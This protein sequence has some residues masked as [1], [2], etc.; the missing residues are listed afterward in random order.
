MGSITSGK[1]NA[2]KQLNIQYFKG[3]PLKIGEGLEDFE[4]IKGRFGYWSRLSEFIWRKA[5]LS[6]D[7]RQK[8]IINKSQQV[9]MFHQQ[10]FK[11]EETN[12]LRGLLEGL[13][14]INL[15]ELRSEDFKIEFEKPLANISL[16]APTFTKTELVV[17][18]NENSQNYFDYK[19]ID[20]FQN[21][22][23]KGK[24][25]AIKFGV[26]QILGPKQKFT[27]SKVLLSEIFYGYCWIANRPILIRIKLFK[28]AFSLNAKKELI[29]LEYIRELKHIFKEKDWRGQ[30]SASERHPDCNDFD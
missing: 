7:L 26:S 27:I 3:H 5:P 28:R 23:V 9:D 8:F 20:I 4:S 30:F 14:S 24:D 25:I 19:T 15:K 29:V 10:S 11:A 12:Y 13:S 2:K 1:K 18:E 17:E 21:I 16:K 6:N 22:N